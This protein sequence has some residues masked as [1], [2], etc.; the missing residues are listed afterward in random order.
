MSFNSEVGAA[1]VGKLVGKLQ[2]FADELEDGEGVSDCNLGHLDTCG[3]EVGQDRVLETRAVSRR[4]TEDATLDEIKVLHAQS[5]K[6]TLVRAEIPED[7]RLLP[8][9]LA[10]V[11]RPL[12][13]PRHLEAPVATVAGFLVETKAC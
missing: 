11:A 10:F 6:V 9:I 5:V 3:D 1:R 4:G 7:A 2:D 12:A 8:A 13:S